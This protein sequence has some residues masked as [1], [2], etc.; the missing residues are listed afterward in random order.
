MPHHILTS[1][2]VLVVLD[3]CYIHL[4]AP[5]KQINNLVLIAGFMMHNSLINP[6]QKLQLELA[7]L[8][9]KHVFLDDP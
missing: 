4:V 7:N 1:S 2:H 9:R 5:Q 6:N 8:K 3:S